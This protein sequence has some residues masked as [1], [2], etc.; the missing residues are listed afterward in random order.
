VCGI[1]ASLNGVGAPY[2]NAPM[3]S[4]I[5]TLKTELVYHGAY[6]SRDEARADSF[7]SIEAFFNRRRRHSAL[8]Y[9]SREAHE[10]LY[11]QESA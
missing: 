11:H 10:Q 7:E 9:L 1:Q 5:G 3:E 2:D 8:N 6:R 4:F